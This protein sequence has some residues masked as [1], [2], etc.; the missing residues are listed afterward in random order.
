M[1]RIKYRYVVCFVSI[2]SM[3]SNQP[4]G[5]PGCQQD[6]TIALRTTEANLMCTIRKSVQQCHG[7]IGMG[8]CMT[9]VRLIYWCPQSGLLVLRC[10]R[11]QLIPIRAALSMITRIETGTC[12]TY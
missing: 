5:Y 8:K 7:T 9:R 3:I 1:T 12:E 2:Q 6:D 10:L 4:P 11:T